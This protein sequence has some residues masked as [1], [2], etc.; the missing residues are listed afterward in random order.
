MIIGFVVVAI[1][2]G[3]PNGLANIFG[4]KLYTQPSW[5]PVWNFPG[6]FVSEQSSRFLWRFCFGLVV[7][8][9]RVCLAAYRNRC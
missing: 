5:L 1:S 6:G 4:T 2:S 3:L 8:I 9:A 7:N